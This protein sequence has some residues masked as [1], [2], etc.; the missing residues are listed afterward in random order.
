MK[1]FHSVEALAD[2]YVS[3]S[4]AIGNFDGIH[5][6][7]QDLIHSMLKDARNRGIASVVFTFYPHPVEVLNPGKRLQRLTTASEKLSLLEK[8]NVQYTIV[9]HFDQKLAGLSP[10]DFF[11]KFIRNG[12]RAKSVHVG[13]N[14]AFGKGRIGNTDILKDLCTSAGVELFIKEPVTV[15]SEKVSSSLIRELVLNGDTLRA[16]QFLGR[17][18]SLTG[19]VFKGKGRGKDLGFPTANIVVPAEKI[20]PKNGVYVT[21]TVWQRQVFRSITNVGVRP[22][23]ESGPTQPIVETHV[24]DLNEGLV[25]EILEI[26][27]LDRIRDERR[28]PSSSALREQI[29]RDIEVCRKSSSFQGAEN[30]I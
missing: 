17:P 15:A 9:Q 30:E 6:G 23:F 16:M 21:R 29:E 3:S 19:T 12:L 26:Q 20:L 7:H 13:F 25:D 1:V 27:F 10:S 24:L 2:Q 11:D 8:M 22:T 18:Y 5:L 4:T 14:F 28:F